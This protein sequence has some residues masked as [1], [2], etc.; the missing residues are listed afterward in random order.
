MFS[1][2]RNLLLMANVNIVI[3]HQLH[4]LKGLEMI[5]RY[6]ILNNELDE[7]LSLVC[8]IINNVYQSF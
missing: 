8:S 6:I 5:D 1:F 4:N 3:W 7:K 2:E